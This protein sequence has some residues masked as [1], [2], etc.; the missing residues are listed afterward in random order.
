MFCQLII[1][2][3]LVTAI[4]YHNQYY[5]ILFHFSPL[6][7]PFSYHYPYPKIKNPTNLED[8]VLG[9]DKKSMIL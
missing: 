3:N 9:S 2:R 6:P 7:L 4:I 8:G 5:F 1:Y